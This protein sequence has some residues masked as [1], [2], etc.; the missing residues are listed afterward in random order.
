MARRPLR[1]AL[2]VGVAYLA[3]VLTVLFL[4]LTAATDGTRFSYGFLA[5]LGGLTGADFL[6]PGAR[7]WIRSSR[8]RASAVVFGVGMIL[9]MVGARALS[10]A[11]GPGWAGPVLLAWFA[12]MFLAFVVLDQRGSPAGP[13]E[14]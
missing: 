12:P 11:I 1:T 8:G 9:A 10:H 13:A 6:L 5:L 2:C 3:V 7:H 4:G 14:E